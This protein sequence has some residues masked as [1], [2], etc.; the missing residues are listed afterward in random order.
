MKST[1]NDTKRTV[2]IW[3]VSL[4]V[5]AGIGLL[6]V[7]PDF[8]KARIPASYS[9]CV[10]HLKQIDGAKEAWALENK[11]TMGSPVDVAGVNRYLKS[12]A[13]PVCPRGG[14]YSYN[15]VGTNPTCSLGSTLG[16]TL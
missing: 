10:A 4:A 14:T 11:R 5:F 12:S 7:V 6:V 16:H 13:T 15:P 8:V 1:E 2:L 9:A 3:G